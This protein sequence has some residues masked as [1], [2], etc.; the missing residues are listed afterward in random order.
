M[1][2]VSGL[3]ST[4][5]YSSYS[6][7]N[8]SGASQLFQNLNAL[9]TALQSGDPSTAQSALS[10]LQTT[11]SSNA[12]GST[13][14]PFGNNTAAN[15]DYNTLVNAVNSGN[16]TDAQSALTKLKA[17]LKSGHAHGHHHHGGGAPPP[18]P[19]S[20]TDSTD[21]TSS[22]TGTSGNILNVTV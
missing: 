10:T 7:A 17:D 15:S 19:T 2:T 21:T 6:S 9:G 4:D 5:L 12:Q 8:Q 16:T 13:S 11:V 18:A 20:S 14:Q 1:S 22:T 3:S